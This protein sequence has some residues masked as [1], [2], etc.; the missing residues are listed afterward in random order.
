MTFR[1]FLTKKQRIAVAGLLALYVTCLVASYAHVRGVQMANVI[2]NTSPEVAASPIMVAGATAYTVLL[3]Y[4]LFS[5]P[6]FHPLSS[7][8]FASILGDGATAVF[9]LPPSWHLYFDTLCCGWLAAELVRQVLY[10]YSFR[11]N[12]TQD[13]DL[14]DSMLAMASER[15]LQGA[16]DEI[17]AQFFSLVRRRA[18]LLALL[19]GVAA[20]AYLL[21]HGKPF[22]IPILVFAFVE[23]M[24]C[25][26]YDIIQLL[27]VREYVRRFHPPKAEAGTA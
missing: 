16:P 7:P 5:L 3:V 17:L 4:L 13:K 12:P 26:H 2:L 24:L 1:L 21:S 15:K 11:R 9:G 19:P 20:A 14:Y 27:R 6:S 25:R 18:F 10:E 23:N 8:I 22:W